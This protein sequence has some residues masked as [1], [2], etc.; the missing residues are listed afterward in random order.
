MTTGGMECGRWLGR[1][2]DARGTGPVD[3]SSIRCFRAHVWCANHLSCFFSGVSNRW[4]NIL[5]TKSCVS[6]MT[7]GLLADYE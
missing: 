2:T 4:E 6:M 3:Y 1:A 7:R 5:G